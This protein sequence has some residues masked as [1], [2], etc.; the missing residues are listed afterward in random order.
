M[1]DFLT[2]AADAL[3]IG[4]TSLLARPAR[5]RGTAEGAD[6]RRIAV[7][8]ATEAGM[9][10][11]RAAAAA[12]MLNPSSASY[13]LRTHDALLATDPVYALAFETARSRVQ[14]Q[15]DGDSDSVLIVRRRGYPFGAVHAS[16]GLDSKAACGIVFPPNGRA[17]EGLVIGPR[18]LIGD[19]VGSDGLHVGWHEIG[20]FVSCG[21]CV[22]AL[23]SRR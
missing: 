7:A 13:A 17:L 10:R 11:K 18:E 15:R 3:G 5:R 19:G 6:A 8:L 2:A 4:G 23:R 22:S 12:G 1:T 9:T 20:R 14:D 21:R 16:L